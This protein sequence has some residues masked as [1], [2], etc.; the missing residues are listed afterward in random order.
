[1]SSTY[2]TSSSS[3][4]FRLSEH[5]D[6]SASATPYAQA[7][8]LVDIRLPFSLVKLALGLCHQ[9]TICSRRPPA[10]YSYW[11][12]DGKIQWNEGIDG[13]E[14][15]DFVGSDLTMILKVW[16]SAFSGEA[17][18]H[19][20]VHTTN[21]SFSPRYWTHLQLA[22]NR[23]LQVFSVTQLAESGFS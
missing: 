20:V 4:N 8:K 7:Q 3:Y 12:R 9:F 6:A 10:L 16:T 13:G 14:P 23:G 1:M 2:S 22:L 18:L 15:G 5:C 11:L 17:L 21:I 19:V